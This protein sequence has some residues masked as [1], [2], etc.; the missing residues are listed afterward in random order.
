MSLWNEGG[1][2][3]GSLA[4]GL[5]RGSLLLRVLLRAADADYKS[6]ASNCVI[7]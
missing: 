1:F 6:I 7:L 4:A 5:T 2:W 3:L